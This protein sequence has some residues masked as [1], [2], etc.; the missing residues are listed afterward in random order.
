IF[1]YDLLR[2]LCRVVGHAPALDLAVYSIRERKERQVM[3]GFPRLAA[4]RQRVPTA[5]L[6]DVAQAVRDELARIALRTRIA[7][8]ARIAVG[9][10][11]RGITDYA[12]IVKTVVEELQR[13]G[14][15]PFIFPAMGSHGGATAQGQREVLAEAGITPQAMGCPI[16]SAM[17]VV[18][19]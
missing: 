18:R 7:S 19:V 9:A 15:A 12:P 4:I 3:I 2:E 6:G 13:L 17:D 1:R 5:P 14:A 16:L 10:G 8:E 11:S